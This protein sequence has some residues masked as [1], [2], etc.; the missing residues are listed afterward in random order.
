MRGDARHEIIPHRLSCV[1][2]A[3]VHVPEVIEA[4][5]ILGALRC[6]RSPL[7]PDHRRKAVVR[8]NAKPQPRGALVEQIVSQLLK[9]CDHP[10][11]RETGDD[12]CQCTFPGDAL[13]EQFL[14]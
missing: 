14:E 11:I 3:E 10:G 12:A 2:E 7:K 9:S 13:P 6:F 4:D 5:E 1:P 8:L